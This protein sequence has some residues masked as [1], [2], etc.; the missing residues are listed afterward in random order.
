MSAAEL[1]YRPRRA[2]RI[3]RHVRLEATSTPEWQAAHVASDG[4]CLFH[5][6]VLCLRNPHNAVRVQQSYTAAALRHLVVASVHAQAPEVQHWRALLHADAETRHE[7]AFAA[8]L[9][10]GVTDAAVRQVRANMLDKDRYWGDHFAIN[11]LT[12]LLELNVL[13]ITPRSRSVLPRNAP[14]ERTVALQLDTDNQHYR[15]LLH[16]QRGVFLRQHPAI[17]LLARA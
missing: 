14:Y 13:V 7:V 11:T 17:V 12:R 10:D 8:P 1:G 9:M 5:S 6:L 4:D 2:D 3:A 16:R 15:P